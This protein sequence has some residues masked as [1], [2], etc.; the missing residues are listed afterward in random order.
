[1]LRVGIV[2]AGSLGT[3]HANILSSLPEVEVVA[4]A[5]ADP[6]RAKRLAGRIGARAES[7][8]KRLVNSDSVEA[9]VITVPSCYHSDYVQMAACAGKHAFSEKPLAR[10]RQQAEEALNATE[11][12]GTKFAVGQVVRW[13]PAYEHAR[14]TILSGTVGT[15]GMARLSRGGP[16]PHGSDN[17]YADFEKSGGVLL[18]MSIHDIDWLIWTFGKVQRVY[19]RRATPGGELDSSMVCMRHESGV[20]SYAEASWC[21]PTFSTSIEVSGTDGVITTNNADTNPLKVEYRQSEGSMPANFVPMAASRSRGPFHEEDADWSSWFQGGPV[22]RCTAKQ[23][24]ES[25]LVGLTALESAET[26]RTIEL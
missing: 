8:P 15:P 7:D 1:M 12:A 17:W 3:S 9:V 21:L 19:A 26:G 24:F 13:F 20:I 4:V 6:D 25:L 16:F 23:A 2:G 11:K 5:D 14:N 10:T 22:P 18:D